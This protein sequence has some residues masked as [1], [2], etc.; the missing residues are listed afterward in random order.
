MSRFVFLLVLCALPVFFVESGTDWAR[1][2]VPLASEGSGPDQGVPASV[3]LPA[4]ATEPGWDFKAPAARA[5]KKKLDAAL[6]EA[7]ATF[8][9]AAGN[10]R[11]ALIKDLEAAMKE[12]TRAA[13]LDEALKLR[14]AIVSIKNAGATENRLHKAS[15]PVGQWRVEFANGVAETC[16]IQAEGTAAV[17]EPQR[18]CAGKIGVQAGWFLISYDDDRVERWTPV[19]RNMVVE[20]WFPKTQFPSAKGVLGIGRL[21]AQQA[22]R[23]GTWTAVFD[24]QPPT[25]PKNS[26]TEEFK[27]EI[28]SLQGDWGAVTVEEDGREIPK[29][30]LKKRNQLLTFKGDTFRL[31]DGTGAYQGTFQIDPKANPKAIDLIWKRFGGGHI[32]SEQTLVAQGIYELEGET[33]RIRHG[34]KKTLAGGHAGI[35][36]VLL[37]WGDAR[38]KDFKTSGAWETTI[39]RRLALL[40]TRAVDGKGPSIVFDNRPEAGVPPEALAQMHA[41]RPAKE[42]PLPGQ[43]WP[44]KLHEITAGTIR[45]VR[46]RYFNKDSWATE[47]QARE[48]VRG[49]LAHKSLEAF[50]FQIWSQGVGV[51]E[52]ECRVEFTDEYREKLSNDQKPYWEG[53][54]LIWNTESCFRDATGRWWF[55][56][57]FDHFHSSHPKGDRKLSKNPKKCTPPQFV[58]KWTVTFANGAV[59]TCDVRATWTASESE[60]KRS[61]D[62][63]A[64]VKGNALV[65][66]FADDRVEQWTI[67]DKRVVVEHFFPGR[68]FP[69]GARVLGIADR[70]P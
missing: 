61:A 42:E 17:T 16:S 21:A 9:R 35:S 8:P 3:P 23:P 67:V 40:R 44:P 37:V 30:E 53:R 48:Y 22:R 46:I 36:G 58:G 41:K 47:E 65:I 55:V 54:L 27:M 13:D 64:E 28:K 5:T 59:E 39:Y 34:S 10:A 25:G 38:P 15:L 19:G 52:I 20:H 56:T 66:S 11:K 69:A 33:L 45:T 29:E 14:A 51:P 32:L 12:A 68:E 50:G 1:G 49:Y 6:T 7:D 31:Q 26:E 24:G 2:S 70:V 63:K 43:T 57:L 18:T 4:L 60:P 62:G